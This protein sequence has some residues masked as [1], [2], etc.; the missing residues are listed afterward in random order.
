MELQDVNKLPVICCITCTRGRHSLLER[1]LGCIMKQDY[2]GL[3]YYIIFNNSPVEQRLAEN[4]DTD[5]RKI[6]LVNQSRWSKTGEL[7]SNT[8]QFFSDSVLHVPEDVNLISFPDDDDKYLPSHIRKGVLG[9]LEA[10]LN[11]KIAYKPFYSLME[12][13]REISKI[14]NVCEPSIFVSKEHILKTGFNEHSSAFHHQWITKLTDDNLLHEPLDGEP[15]F[16]YQWGDGNYHMSGNGDNPD[17][18]ANFRKYHQDEGD[19]IITPTY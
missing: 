9:Y 16:I 14:N 8:H 13:G 11:N 18:L 5:T 3:F 2:E 6:I 19:G 7:Y 12:Q 15:T 17:N 1:A 4:L 10:I